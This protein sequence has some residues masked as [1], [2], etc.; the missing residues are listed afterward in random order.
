MVDREKIASA[1]KQNVE[2]IKTGDWYIAE[3]SYDGQKFVVQNVSE[4]TAID[5]LVSKFCLHEKDKN[6][7]RKKSKLC[8]EFNQSREAVMSCLEA[9]DHR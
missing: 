4:D 8:D 5:K 2:I 9:E 7:K 6:I 3:A 1:V